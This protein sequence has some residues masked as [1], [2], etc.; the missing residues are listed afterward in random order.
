MTMPAI[1]MGMEK[2]LPLLL[3]GPAELRD[4]LIEKCH[5]LFV[6][7]IE[8]YRAAGADVLLYSNPFGSTDQ[9]P[10]KFFL[11]H[12]LPW[13]E[14]DIQAVGNS[15]VVYY[16]GGSRMNNVV[17]IV[18]QRTGIGVYYLSPWDDVSEG[19]KNLGE[20]PM[21]WGVINDI[22][23]IDWNTSEVDAE[24][25][26]IIDAGKPHGKFGFGTL[27]MPFNIP[28]QNIRAMLDAAFRYGSLEKQPL[29]V[30]Y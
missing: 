18:R 1:L 5:L 15:G 27:V 25:K 16:V 20:G 21:S 13:I 3:S 8:A 9:I 30:N 10:M 17:D 2:W 6:R 7:Q 12:S 26:R 28:E 23:L 14:K 22:K 11:N 24:V 19:Q 4:Q 29:A